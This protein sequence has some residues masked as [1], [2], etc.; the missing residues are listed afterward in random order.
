[1]VYEFIQLVKLK[2]EIE[3]TETGTEFKIARFMKYKFNSLIVKDANEIEE[4]KEF[5]YKKSAR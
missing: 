2:K 4:W 5:Q 1:V 3:I